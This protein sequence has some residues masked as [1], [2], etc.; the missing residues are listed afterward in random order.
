M[1]RKKTG[2]GRGRPRNARN[3]RTIVQDLADMRMPL[4]G[5]GAGAPS[6]PLREAVI[7]MLQ[8]LA[9]TGDI[10]ADKLL[11]KIRAHVAPEQ[12]ISFGLLVVPEMQD[13]DTWIRE[14][15]IRNKYLKQPEMP[16][17]PKKPFGP[18]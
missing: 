16:D 2:R 14:A 13:A 7:L 11:D 3:T 9:M 8:N 5:S 18:P 12:P 6:V 10:E 1:T 4:Q 15:Q 17:P